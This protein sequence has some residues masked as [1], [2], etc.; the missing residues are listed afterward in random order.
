MPETSAKRIR[1]DANAEARSLVADR[2]FLAG[3]S[4]EISRCD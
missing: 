2:L 3:M 4:S 1:L